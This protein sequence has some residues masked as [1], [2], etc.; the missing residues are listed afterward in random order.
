MTI[1][2]LLDAFA[3]NFALSAAQRK[4]ASLEFDGEPLDPASTLA[5]V[6]DLGDDDVLDVKLR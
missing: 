3:A 5:D 4:S 6:E 2:E 1:R